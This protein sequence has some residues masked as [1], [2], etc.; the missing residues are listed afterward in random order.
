MQTK[1]LIVQKIAT[2]QV[3]NLPDLLQSSSVL[4][5][6]TQDTETVSEKSLVSTFLMNLAL[7]ETG[8]PN[9]KSLRLLWKCN[10]FR[11]VSRAKAEVSTR[12]RWHFLAISRVLETQ[13]RIGV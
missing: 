3:K 12:V 5:S 4:G 9:C 13:N 2:F 11:M 1:E 7:L 10:L 8:V 6:A